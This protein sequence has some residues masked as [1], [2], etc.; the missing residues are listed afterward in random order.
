MKN[1]RMPTRKLFYLPLIFI[2]L[3][4]AAPGCDKSNQTPCENNEAPPVQVGLIFLDKQ[5]GENILLSKNIESGTIKI[6]L[7]SSEVPET[8]GTIVTSAGSD[9]YG[10]LKFHIEDLKKGNFKYTV[11]IPDVT[12]TRLSYNNTEEKTDNRCKP[13]VIKIED[14]VIA[15]HQYTVQRLGTNIIIKITL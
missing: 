14:P 9:L 3:V 7:D 13:Y 6:T 8:T 10:S 11:S 12:T 15:E 1:N 2:A 5:T 4:F